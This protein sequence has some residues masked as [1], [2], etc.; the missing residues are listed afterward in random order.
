MQKPSSHVMPS[1]T[2]MGM[3]FSHLDDV[4]VSVLNCDD[5]VGWLRTNQISSDH[6]QAFKGMLQYCIY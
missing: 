3:N 1:T 4:D 6:C 5:F 2:D